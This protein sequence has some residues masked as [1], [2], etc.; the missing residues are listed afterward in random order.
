M[1]DVAFKYDPMGNRVLKARIP[2][3]GGR[4]KKQ[5]IYWDYTI[6]MRD[7]QGNVMATYDMD[8]LSLSTGNIQEKYYLSEQNI[9]GSSRVGMIKSNEYI[10][11]REF[12]GSVSYDG[13]GYNE[14]QNSTVATNYDP[15]ILLFS[16]GETYTDNRGDRYYELTNHLGN[17][18]E[19]ITDRKIPEPDLSNDI[20]Y[21]VADV[22]SYSDYFPFGMQMPG[23]NGSTGDYR[24]G[25]Q[26]QEK[27]DEIKGE[28]NSI[29][30]KYRMHD[31]RI[32]RF[33]A[34]DPLADEYPWNS[35]YAFSENVVIHMVELE[36]LEASSTKDKAK[37]T[38]SGKTE[39]TMTFK[40]KAVDNTEEMSSSEIEELKIET[41]A[42]I[43]DVYSYE[44]D[45]TKITTTVEWGEDNT[46]EVEFTDEVVDK[47]GVFTM[48]PNIIGKTQHMGKN[49]TQTNNFQV[50]VG[51]LETKDGRT[52]RLSQTEI[53]RTTGHEVAHGM[54]EKH[55][56][57][58]RRMFQKENI[59]NQS[60]YSEGTELNKRQLKRMSRRIRRESKKAN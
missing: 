13:M 18:L 34:V 60:K 25:F 19:V 20:D 29:N 55:H 44:D 5:G 4:G 33:F 42:F 3:S 26:G 38:E 9:Y 2:R 14:S 11:E 50:R 17:V 51:T 15:E 30:Y 35:P 16:F 36:G 32:G 47:N 21:Y 54:K 52:I 12:E 1:N 49:S 59:L 41:A 31:P 58:F 45:D 24:Y 39:I 43:E 53:K 22:V 48:P 23:R 56:H 27:D 28:G 8:L 10:A 6:Y 46:L 37:D 57:F 40:L 7:A